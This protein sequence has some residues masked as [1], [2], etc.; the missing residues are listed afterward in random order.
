VRYSLGNALVGC[1]RYEDA[2]FE[3]TSLT[4]AKEPAGSKEPLTAYRGWKA[5][6]WLKQGEALEKLRRWEE[7]Q[8]IYATVG[9]DTTLPERER[10]EAQARSAWI[11][12]NVRRTTQP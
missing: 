2:L 9:I 1:K 6:A 11:K 10:Q 12:A 3:L 4:A 7:A 8:A 5:L